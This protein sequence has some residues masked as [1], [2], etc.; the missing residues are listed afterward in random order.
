MNKS[1]EEIYRELKEQVNLLYDK[2][3]Q[4]EQKHFTNVMS[5]GH[6]QYPKHLE[7][8]STAEFYNNS[9]SEYTAHKRLLELM[10]KHRDKEENLLNLNTFLKELDEIIAESILSQRNDLGSV[11][12]E[13]RAKLSSFI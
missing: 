3:K 4:A 1:T 10:D 6:G 9:I 11:F 13:W 2:V 12:T 7:I 8:R 5:C